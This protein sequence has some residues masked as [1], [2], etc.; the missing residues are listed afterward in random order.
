MEIHQWA[1][2]ITGGNPKPNRS[3]KMNIK[4]LSL[5][6]LFGLF[7]I[8]AFS[9][10]RE[11]NGRPSATKNNSPKKGF[12]MD[13]VV[14]G[15]NFGAQFGSVTVVQ[16]N[17]TAGYKLKESWLVGVSATY[18][19]FQDKRFTPSYVNNIYGGSVFS[20][21]Y[22]LE[23][24]IAHAEYEVLNVGQEVNRGRV[25]VQ[26]FLVG[27]GYRSQIGGNS[28]ANIM[29]LYNVLDDLN[30]PYSNPIIRI[31]FGIGL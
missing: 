25:N 3:Y 16:L 15:G 1:I 23:N 12:Q 24:F 22:F 29:L 27:G 5:F 2:L 8:G 20:Q 17:P 31:G 14:L 11:D 21:Y 4:H 13:K 6:L 26:A 7:C 19:Y 28:I 9:Q 10:A 30:Y 18:L